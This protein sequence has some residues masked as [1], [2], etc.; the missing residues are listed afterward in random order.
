MRSQLLKC[1]ECLLSTQQK[2]NFEAQIID[3]HYSRNKPD[4]LLSRQLMGSEDN[5][6]SGDP[7]GRV[8]GPDGE[9]IA[10]EDLLRSVTLFILVTHNDLLKVG[11]S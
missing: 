10:C 11:S 9:Q 5:S 3:A 4:I 6:H 8:T 1:D 7:G 2:T